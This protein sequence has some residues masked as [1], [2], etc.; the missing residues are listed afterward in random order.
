MRDGL[1]R[2]LFSAIGLVVG[3]GHL[4]LWCKGATRPDPRY[5][6]PGHGHV[7][8]MQT[9]SAGMQKWWFEAV[10]IAQVIG[11]PRAA[12]PYFMDEAI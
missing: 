1:G 5:K 8:G 3:R 12:E 6:L 9:L 7:G 4:S 11:Q 2:V 10:G